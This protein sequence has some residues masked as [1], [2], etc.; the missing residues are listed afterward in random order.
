MVWSAVVQVKKALGMSKEMVLVVYLF[1]D[2]L[3]RD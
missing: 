2:G 3:K 1:L